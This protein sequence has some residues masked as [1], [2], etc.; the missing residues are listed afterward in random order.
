MKKILVLFA[1]MSLLVATNASA[2]FI[3]TY[4]DLNTADAN[5]FVDDG[6]DGITE[7]FYEF[8]YFAETVSQISN[9]GV[10]V[11][12]GVARST[13]LNTVS[14]DIPGDTEQYG[15]N[16]GLAFVWNN[17]TGQVTSN[18]G[19]VIEAIYTSGTFD[20]YLD[21]DPYAVNLGTPASLTDG[22]KIA[23]VEITSGGYRL[24]TTGGAG[25][26]YTLYGDFTY[27]LDNFWYNAANDEDLA[28]DLLE[29][30]W[31]FAYTA[32]DNDPESVDIAFN[33]DGSLVVSSSHDSS[34]SVGVVPEPSTFL[35]LGA[36]LLGLGFVS[37]RKNRN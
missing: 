1:A 21:F 37:R 11:D 15:S 16:W 33:D 18:V 22:T 7:P 32:G 29:K 27:I 24:D 25:S 19:G 9:T 13:G 17:L 26:S 4:F 2:G 14:G 5:Y 28:D 20:F 35:L 12:S 36:G 23:T 6:G 31:V 30:G 34:I 8:T 10:I 3:D